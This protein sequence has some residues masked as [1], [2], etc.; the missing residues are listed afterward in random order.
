M[1]QRRFQTF[2]ARLNLWILALGSLVFIS[3]LSVNYYLSRQLLEE[4]V[5]DLAIST[6]NTAVSNIE[7]VL[8]SVSD[9]ADTLAL[10]VKLNDFQ[11]ENTLNSIQTSILANPDV[12]GMTVAL[13]PGIVDGAVAGFAPYYYRKNDK[14]EYADLSDR[15]YDYRQWDWYTRPFSDGQASWSEPYMDDGGGNTQMTTYSTPVIEAGKVIGVATADL[16]LSWLHSL[17]EAINIGDAA[18]GFIVSADDIVIAH[19]NAAFNMMKLIDTLDNRIIPENW[20]RYLDSKRSDEAVYLRTPCRHIEGDC[21]VAIES[22]GQTGWKIVIILPE[23]ELVADIRSLTL[24]NAIVSV[25]GLALLLLIITQVT[26]RLTRPL[27]SLALATRDIGKGNLDAALPELSSRDE[28][29]TLSR[30]FNTMRLSLRDHIEQVR[31]ATASKQKLESEIQIARDIQMSMIPG[32]GE[33]SLTEQSHDLFAYLRPAKSVGGDLYYFSLQ[34]N[35]LRFIVGD[36]SDKGVPAAIF[37]AKT[38]T[39]YTRALRDGLTPGETFTMMNDI[40]SDNNDACMFVTALC[41]ELDLD[42]GHLVMANAGHMHPISLQQDKATELHVDG[43][44]ALGL[45]SDISY[46]DIDIELPHDTALFMYTDG[47]SEAR[48]TDDVE[49]GEGRLL[50]MIEATGSDGI[51]L[52]GEAIIT[53]V[54]AF[55]AQREQF[56]DITLFAIKYH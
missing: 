24:M 23:A 4:Y 10:Q 17:V 30:D 28:I 25:L 31:Q 36:V 49:Y 53:D 22:L 54:D 29:S 38:V 7:S 52:T 27:S 32:A 15:D 16:E 2:S 55:A 3:V 19:P 1:K 11:E 13:E 40:L 8:L 26:H 21:R 44:T 48:N 33:L 42:T 56:D 9:S 46:D 12:Y 50:K 37:M 47:I 41:G 51:E 35:R 39:L 45:M 14:L 18:Y 34:D 5:R 20:Q 43:A 6:I